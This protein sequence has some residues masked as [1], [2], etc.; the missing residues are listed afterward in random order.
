MIKIDYDTALKALNDAVK[1][2]GSDFVY[3]S[4]PLRLHFSSKCT[5]VHFKDAEQYDS[6]EPTV[7]G[8][9]VGNAMLRLGV[10]LTLL[11]E[12]NGAASNDLI[13][14]M[15]AAN[16]VRVT[17]KATY[18]LDYV[19]RLQDSGTSWGEAVGRGISRTKSRALWDKEER[20]I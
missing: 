15:E 6:G 1:E 14:R 3:K 5:Y 4:D 7:P 8:C 10:P 9:I 19:Q 17:D 18:L 20:A 16:T 13:L 12:N 2:K 11:Q